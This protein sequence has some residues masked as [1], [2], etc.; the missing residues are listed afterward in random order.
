M[1]VVKIGIHGRFA[2]RPLIPTG[3]VVNGLRLTVF[4]LRGSYS[5]VGGGRESNPVCCGLEQHVQLTTTHTHAH[6]EHEQ[7]DKGSGKHVLQ[8]QIEACNVPISHGYIVWH[9]R[10]L[11]S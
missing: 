1:C 11:L 3:K 5:S 6:T 7:G 8:A 4:R 2:L 10:R 9:G